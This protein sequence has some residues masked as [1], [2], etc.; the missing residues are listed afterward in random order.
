MCMYVCVSHSLV[1]DSATPWTVNPPGFLCPWNF[2][3]KNT[4]VGCHFLLQGDFPDPG[5]EPGSS[6]LQVDSLLRKPPGKPRNQSR[7]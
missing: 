4:R 3:G 5:I 2:P 7:H 6:A 1:P